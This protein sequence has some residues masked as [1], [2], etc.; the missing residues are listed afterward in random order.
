MTCDKITIAHPIVIKMKSRVPKI[1]YN[2]ALNF[3]IV[4]AEHN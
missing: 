2:R 3:E 1:T 4:Y